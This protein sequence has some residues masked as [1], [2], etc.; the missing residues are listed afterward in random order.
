MTVEQLIALQQRTFEEK[1]AA[2]KADVGR[3]SCAGNLKSFFLDY[4]DGR[5]DETDQQTCARVCKEIYNG[6]FTSGAYIEQS[7]CDYNDAVA[8]QCN[9]QET[10][11]CCSQVKGGTWGW[12]GQQLTELALGTGRNCNFLEQSTINRKN[13]CIIQKRLWK[14][15]DA[16]GYCSTQRLPPAPT[17]AEAETGRIEEL[18]RQMSECVSP[19]RWDALTAACVSANDVPPIM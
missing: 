19:M 12:A 11:F 5:E 16:T 15:S 17:D 1:A 10:W 6:K 3:W 4:K 8:Q 7:T 18:N 2:D 13:K 9:P 14:G